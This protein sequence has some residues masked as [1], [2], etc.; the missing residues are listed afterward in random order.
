MERLFEIKLALVTTLGC[1]GEGRSAKEQE[2]QDMG[3]VILNTV[4]W[5]LN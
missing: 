3:H 2:H 1:G 5:F 4:V